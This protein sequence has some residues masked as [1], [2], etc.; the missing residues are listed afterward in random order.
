[1]WTPFGRP[2]GVFRSGLAQSPGGGPPGAPPPARRPTWAYWRMFAIAGGAVADESGHGRALAVTNATIGT[3]GACGVSLDFN[4]TNAHALADVLPV[5]NFTLSMWVSI[6]EFN[7]FPLQVRTIFDAGSCALNSYNS[8]NVEGNATG[9]IT[10]V[11]NAG[12]TSP[13]TTV[14]AVDLNHLMLRRIG[15]AYKF[16]VGGGAFVSWDESTAHAAYALTLG[17]DGA[18]HRLKGSLSEVA[19]WDSGLTQDVADEVHALGLAA[20]SL[21]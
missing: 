18:G 7:A 3:T 17:L 19:I 16:S 13:A 4:G 10:A 6:A 12:G 1:M 5:G 15:A 11:D 8:D 21:M 9:V 2:P 14:T 20:T